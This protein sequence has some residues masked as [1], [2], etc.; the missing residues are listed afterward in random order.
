VANGDFS[1]GPEEVLIEDWCQQFP[2]HSIG[3]LRFGPDGAL[4]VSG[5]EGANFNTEDYGQ[6]GDPLNPCGDPPAGVGGTETKPT[7]EGG[8][9]RSQDLRTTGDPTGLSGAILRVDP[10]TGAALPDNPLYGSPDAN[11]RR[12]I[13]YGDRNPFRF[14]IRPGT[15]EVW[16]GNVGWGRWEEIN[17]IPNPTDSIVEDF[18]WPCYENT[19]PEYGSL[20]ICTGWTQTPPYFAYAHGTNIVPGESCPN[21]DS[22]ITGLAFYTGGTYPSSYNNAL[23]FA[24]YSRNC[25][26]VMYPGVNGLPDPTNIANFVQAAASPVDLEIGP[27]GDLFYVDY[28]GGTLRRITYTPGDQP[29]V[30]V[31]TANPTSGPTPLTVNFDGSGSYDPDPGDTLTYSWDLNGDGSF[32]DSTTVQPTYTYANAGTYTVGLMVTD[33]H[34]ASNTTS[35]VITAGNRPP[36]A[37]IDTP[38]STL[39]WRVG[40]LISFSGHATDPEE[41]NLAASDL[42]WTVI[43]HHCPSDCHI[44]IVQTFA[45]VAGGSF[46][47]PDHEYPSY[48]EIQLTATDSGGLQSTTSVILQP[49]TVSL[50]FKTTPTGLSLTVNGTT[51]V[52]TFSKTVIV[53]SSNSLTAISPQLLRGKRYVFVSWSDGGGQSHNIV[54]GSSSATYTATYKRG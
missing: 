5:G 14:T 8:A 12:T 48:L 9:L 21:G 15:N 11:A 35:V 39:K 40:Q 42:S 10:A 2:S 32:G 43:L 50:S 24:D 45:G 13:S 26:W 7:A 44:H 41:G 20:N 38:A 18:G 51:A 54:A 28:L 23:F 22:S 47:A 36:T 4:Y 34:G 46:N 31:A 33:N 6:Y 1:T 3:D 53:G 27:G 16:V 25:I 49:L 19:A 29:P 30:A 17:R 37:I 52:A